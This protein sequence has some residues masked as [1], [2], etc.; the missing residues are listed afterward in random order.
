MDAIFSASNQNLEK[1]YFKVKQGTYEEYVQDDKWKT[2]VVLI[3][4]GMDNVKISFMILM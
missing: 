1:Y 2:H 3:G 4:E